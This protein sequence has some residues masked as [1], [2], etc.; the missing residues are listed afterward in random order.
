MCEREGE[1]ERASEREEGGGG[2]LFFDVTDL[3]FLPREVGGRPVSQRRHA[4][5]LL[6]NCSLLLPEVRLH[7]SRV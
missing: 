6:L 4:L 5:D 2:D 3:F 1:S 7:V